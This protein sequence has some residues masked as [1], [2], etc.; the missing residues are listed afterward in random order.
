MR[1]YLRDD[2]VC[3]ACRGELGWDIIRKASRA[4]EGINEDII[5]ASAT[6]RICGAMYPVRDG[7]ALFLTPDLPR[8]DMW[9][10]VEGHLSQHVSKNPE[11][12]KRLLG[13]ALDDL[14]PADKFVRGLVLSDRGDFEGASKAL[15]GFEAV[16]TPEYNAAQKSQIAHLVD[17][18]SRQPGPVIDLASG[19][20]AL[21]K[22]LVG[23]NPKRPLVVTDFSPRVLRSN[24]ARHAFMGIGDN[25]DYLAFDARKMP[26]RTRG[27]P[28]FT[29]H[30]GLQNMREARSAVREVARVLGGTLIATAIFYPHGD[31]ETDK[32]LEDSGF[33]DTCYRERF[34][35]VCEAAGLSLSVENPVHARAL[36]TPVSEITGIGMDALPLKEMTLEWCT[37]VLRPRV[38]METRHA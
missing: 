15:A 18:V 6:C 28:L 29:S 14:G 33:A 7:I 36:P 11:I 8:D 37:V 16:Y 30:V 5:E 34:S 21:V 9:E 25:V 35:E 2:L 20:G 1:E 38:G 19:M 17:Q 4:G 27:V 22:P 32:I 24:K 26:F 31:P 13:S 23:S 12:E 3:P 10:Q